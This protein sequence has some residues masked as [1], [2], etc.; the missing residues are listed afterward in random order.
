MERSEGF[1]RASYLKVQGG[2]LSIEIKRESNQ[3]VLLARH[4]DVNGNTSH[5][6]KNQPNSSH[7]YK[8][9]PHLYTHFINDDRSS[10]LD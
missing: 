9:Y 1:A 5:L 2:F 10:S 7:E 3:P 4:H 6:D 8:S